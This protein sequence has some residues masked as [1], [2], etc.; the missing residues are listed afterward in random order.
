MHRVRIPGGALHTPKGNFMSVIK[1][2][3]FNRNTADRNR[4]NWTRESMR[5]VV[6]ALHGARVHVE[7]DK[8]AGTTHEGRLIRMGADMVLL[9]TGAGPDTWFP[10]FMIGVI[11][12]PTPLGRAKWE[13]LDVLRESRRTAV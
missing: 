5:A 9:R 10:L 3:D 13:A 7:I 4:D 1:A 11:L 8:D 6:H 2:R 12:D